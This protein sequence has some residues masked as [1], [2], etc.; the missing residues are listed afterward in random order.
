[1][2]SLTIDEFQT[3][4]REVIARLRPDESIEIIDH[5]QVVAR[6]SPPS[7]PQPAGRRYGACRDL[8][9]VIQDDDTHLADFAESM[10]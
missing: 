8:L 2:S 3:R 4:L 9:T 5:G 1:M 10:S 7:P 6:L